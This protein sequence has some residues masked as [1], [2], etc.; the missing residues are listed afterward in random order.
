MAHCISFRALAI[1]LLLCLANAF[2]VRV[3]ADLINDT[4]NNQSESKIDPN[5]T[6]PDVSSLS[7][8]SPPSLQETTTPQDNTTAQGNSNDTSSV[9]SHRWPCKRFNI[10]SDSI[11]YLVPNDTVYTE[12]LARMNTTH[13]CGLLLFYSPYCEF[14]TNFAPLY[15]AI[16]RS[17]PDLAVM[18]FDAH[19]SISL[20]ARY[21]VVGRYGRT[22][23]DNSD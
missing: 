8:V 17:Y 2:F 1:L 23:R 13:G 15:N 3:T 21:G 19:E 22:G 14:C 20:A 7:D 10:S 9:P 11:T 6:L 4:T 16:G 18:A 12:I 5:I